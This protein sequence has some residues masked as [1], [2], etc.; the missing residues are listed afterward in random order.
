MAGLHA[1]GG[2]V[3][4]GAHRYFGLTAE[5][6]LATQGGR[7]YNVSNEL[8]VDTIYNPEYTR[9]THRFVSVSSLSEPSAPAARGGS[10]GRIC[11]GSTRSHTT[12]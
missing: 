5:C 9:A 4:G 3:L 11:T 10:Q 7:L 12:E 2:G 1:R 8:Y 6:C